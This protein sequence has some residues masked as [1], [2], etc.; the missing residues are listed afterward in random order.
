MMTFSLLAASQ[1][2][3]YYDL[4]PWN[5]LGCFLMMTGVVLAAVALLAEVLVKV[6]SR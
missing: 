6:V 5:Q 1:V 3:L 4:S 2:S